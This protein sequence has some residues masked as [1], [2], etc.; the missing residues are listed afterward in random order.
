[1]ERTISREKYPDLDTGLGIGGVSY[2]ARGG[3]KPPP[4]LQ[5][6]PENEG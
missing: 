2:G 3:A 6:R 5:R 1:V 4:I